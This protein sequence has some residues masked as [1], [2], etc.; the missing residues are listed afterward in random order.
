M[1]IIADLHIHSKYS[2]ATSPA[3][4]LENLTLNAD[5]KGL[6]LL[7]TGDFTHPYW[8]KELVSTLSDEQG[9]GLFKPSQS[10]D[11]NV[12]FILT[13]EVCT[14][15][16]FEGKS[17]RIHH[18]ILAPSF[19]DVD[20]INDRLARF[21]DLGQDG[22]PNLGMSAAELVEELTGVSRMCELIPAHVWTPWYSLFGAFSG[23][24]SVDD[25]YE[26]ASDKIHALETGLSSDPPMNWRLSELDKYVLVS[27]SD[28]HSPWPWRLGREVNFFEMEEPTYDLLIGSIRDKDKSVLKGTIEVNPAYGKYHWT[29]HRKCAF[30]VPPEKAVELNNLC[31]I[32]HRKLTKG[33]DQRVL[34]LSDRP[35]GFIPKDRIPYRHLLP[36]SEIITTITGSGSLY[37]PSVQ[38]IHTQL[39]ENLGNEFE[40]LLSSSKENIV[41]LVGSVIADAILAARRDEVEIVPGYDGV[42]G[43]VTFSENSERERN[44]EVLSDR[45]DSGTP[46][47]GVDS[48]LESYL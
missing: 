34:E 28:S 2:R 39:I 19:E 26:E 30:S 20:Q 45:V 40:I 47:N 8:L 7:G 27:N 4:D 44:Q 24:D 48:K 46:K 29:G 3:M 41:K 14:N 32:C 18:L 21:G 1:R 38:R 37:S 6:N 42:Y 12:R 5:K 9:I 22:R 23:F 31:P 11:S 36:L 35:L 33:V 13:A 16:E 17:K 15:F 25:C 10:P 43:R